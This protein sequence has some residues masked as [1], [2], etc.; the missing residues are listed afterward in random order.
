MKNSKETLIKRSEKRRKLKEET[1]P[2]SFPHQ[3]EKKCKDCGEIKNCDWQSSFNANGTPQY[4]PR[5]RECN[6]KLHQKRRKARWGVIMENKIKRQK[7]IKQKCI[8]YLGGKCSVCGYKKSIRALTFHHRNRKEKEKTI[9]LM[10]VNNSFEKIK[11]E[12][13]KCILVCFNCHMEI[14]E[15][16][17]K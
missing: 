5:C 8:D 1:D 16:Y 12:L 15:N 6:N 4:K 3:I 17:K 10:I 2:K 9:A 7:I 11:K 14:E 13:D